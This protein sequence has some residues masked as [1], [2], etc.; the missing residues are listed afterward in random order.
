MNIHIL[1]LFFRH[2]NDTKHYTHIDTIHTNSKDAT[3]LWCRR[4]AYAALTRATRVRVPVA[5][6]VFAGLG[7]VLAAFAAPLS[8]QCGTRASAGGAALRH[9]A[10][11]HLRHRRHRH[12]FA[13]HT[14]RLRMRYTPPFLYQTRRPGSAHPPEARAFVR[15][16]I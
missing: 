2:L 8:Y 7:T 3:P 15:N 1:Q 13:L 12:L 6:A 11:G 16:L 4:L 9:T 5:E 10:E 14:P